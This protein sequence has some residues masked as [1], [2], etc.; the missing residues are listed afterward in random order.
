VPALRRWFIACALI[1][2]FDLALRVLKSRVCSATVTSPDDASG[3]V[4]INIP[5]LGSGWRAGQ[6]VRVRIL[7]R[8]LGGVRW[9]E[10]HPLTI[11]GP[12]RA[13]DGS[14]MNLILQRTGAWSRALHAL[15]LTDG[16]GDRE[17]RML[18]KFTVDPIRVRIVV[19]GPYGGIGHTLPASFAG[20]LLVAG[21]AGLS[22]ALAILGDTLRT[23]GGG[24][25]SV[26]LLWAV[27]DPAACAPFLRA[28]DALLASKAP[29]VEIAVVIRYTRAVENAEMRLLL[30]PGVVVEPGRPNLGREF[31]DMARRT[32]H[33]T[34]ETSAEGRGLL[35]A[36][37]GPDGMCQDVSRAVNGLDPA[38]R[39]A[40]GGVE[41]MRESVTPLC[42]TA[43]CT[44]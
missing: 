11:A 5:G 22:F 24:P 44:N 9:A 43:S 26:R 30:P 8:S 25:R 35:V 7:S 16:A 37:C 32:L 38:V 20:A 1:Y 21:G 4:L 3:I 29:G 19:E 31:D 23:R 40:L 17:S 39:D 27:R 33:L 28:L 34:K 36:A 6:H 10:A 2:A 42:L 18:D 41:Y 14:G 13:P 12:P 15:A